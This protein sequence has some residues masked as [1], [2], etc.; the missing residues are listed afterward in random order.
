MASVDGRTERVVEEPSHPREQGLG[1]GSFGR[2]LVA[3]QDLSVDADE[4]GRRLG[5]ADVECDDDVHTAG[6]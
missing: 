2:H 5:A 4:T 6:T 1:V 3:A